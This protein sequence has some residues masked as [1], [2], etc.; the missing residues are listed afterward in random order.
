MFTKTW[1]LRNEISAVCKRFVPMRIASAGFTL[2]EVLVAFAIAA[3]ALA[4]V[5]D[6]AIA[7]LRSTHLASRQAGALAIARS[8]LAALDPQ[9]TVAPGIVEGDEP[10]GYHWVLT[11]VPLGVAAPGGVDTARPLVLYDVRVA[12][13]WN[14]DGVRQRMVALESRRAG[15]ASR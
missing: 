3:L 13:R 15:E 6:G 4:A 7:G 2:L 9:G 14:G 11:V 1:N 10:P 8:H 12:V 5:Y